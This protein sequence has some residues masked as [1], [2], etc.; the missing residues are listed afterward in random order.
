MR[1]FSGIPA[2][3]NWLTTCL[4]EWGQQVPGCGKSVDQYGQVGM[5][6][7][8]YFF[9]PSCRYWSTDFPHP[10]TCWTNSRKQ[11]VSQFAEAGIPE[12]DRIK[13]TSANALRT[14]GLG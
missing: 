11:V 9:G 1:S 12:K 10:A 2:S 13:I 8:Y 3:A 6:H 5:K 14:F 4:R 7:C